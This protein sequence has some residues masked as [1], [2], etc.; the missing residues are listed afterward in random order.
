VLIQTQEGFAWLRYFDIQNDRRNKQ[1]GYNQILQG[2][3]INQG[4]SD[5]A[6]YAKRYDARYEAEG[7]GGQQADLETS[8]HFG[9]QALSEVTLLMKG[10]WVGS[11]CIIWCFVLH[12]FLHRSKAVC[13]L[14]SQ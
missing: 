13:A 9:H 10:S 5:R 12:I 14:Q 4:K 3:T 1:T 7:D 11:E 2:R 8:M 6:E